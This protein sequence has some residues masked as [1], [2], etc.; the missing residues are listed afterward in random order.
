[1]VYTVTGPHRAAGALQTF[2]NVWTC[3]DTCRIWPDMALLLETCSEQD[4]MQ[5]GLLFGACDAFFAV[6]RC[7]DI[8]A[9]SIFRG[10]GVQSNQH[11]PAPVASRFAPGQASDFSPGAAT[12]RSSVGFV[13]SDSHAANCRHACM[14]AAYSKGIRDDSRI[15]LQLFDDSS[16]VQPPM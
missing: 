11:Q 10:N 16:G 15:G 12:A 14:G 8:G 1:M 5:D 6:R 3:L 7:Q 2:S 13:Q 9:A 4:V